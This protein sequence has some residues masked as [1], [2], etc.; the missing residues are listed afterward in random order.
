MKVLFDVMVAKKEI[1]LLKNSKNVLNY[2]SFHF[3]VSRS[4]FNFSPE[5]HSSIYQQ[6][7]MPQN[8]NKIKKKTGN[9]TV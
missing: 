5:L 7:N 2:F 3:F 1:K 6:N 4:M 8:E 9:V